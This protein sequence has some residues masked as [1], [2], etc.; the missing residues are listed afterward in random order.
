MTTSRIGRKPVT[1]PSGVE[2]KIHDGQFSAKGPK[3]NLSIPL[4]PFVIV[5]MENNQILVEPN[6]NPPHKITGLQTKLNRSI[7][8]TIRANIFNI[9]QGITAGYERK[10]QLVGVGYRAQS[11]GKVLS[12]SLGFS[13]PTDFSVPEGV[14]IETPTQT[15]IL[16]KG[17]NK[18]LVGLVAA[19]I[20]S[21]RSPEPYKGKGVRYANEIIELKET[22]KK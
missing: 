11:K 12:L 6:R 19:Q 17:I 16:V 10:L 22:K 13:H 8:G 3:G 21:I 15:E 2:V 20:R 7:A 1:I 5:K 18:E 14:T 9:I 4:H